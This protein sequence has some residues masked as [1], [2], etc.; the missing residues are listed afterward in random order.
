[1]QAKIFIKGRLRL[2]VPA[3]ILLLTAICTLG[4]IWKYNQSLKKN[5]NSK[6]LSMASED[7]G[8]TSANF[9]DYIVITETPV[10][11]P[12]PKPTLTPTPTIHYFTAGELDN[13]FNEASN[14]QSISIDMLR[15]IAYCE[16]GYNPGAVN[17]IYGGLYQFSANTWIVTR[18][19]MNKDT[20]PA[21]RFNPQEA[22]KT[23][24]FKLATEGIHAWPNCSK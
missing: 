13:F 16:S 17:G 21:L 2:F 10:P 7:L 1:M 8:T 15:K 19:A 4:L 22:I 24:A 5:S 11:T 12:T 18:R 14:G 6:I 20:N 3:L 9:I 23:A